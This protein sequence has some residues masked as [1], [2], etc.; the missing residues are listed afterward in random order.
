MH[1]VFIKAQ[2]NLGS[3]RGDASPL[4]W[5]TRI[6]TNHC[7]NIIRAK[8]AAWHEKFRQEVTTAA[9]AGLQDATT[10]QSERS[11]LINLCLDKCDRGVAEVA[12][13]YFVDE[14]TQA[15]I[16]ELVGISA[17]TLRKRLREF[18]RISREEIAAAVPGVQFQAP[19][20]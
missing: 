15:E 19:P 7:L 17:P 12:I 5:L 10:G 1:D 20:I 14:M 3:F 11:Q 13:Y 8:S 2:R 6:A 4:T 18:I 16:A 9:Q